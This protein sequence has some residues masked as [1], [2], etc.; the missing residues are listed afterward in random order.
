MAGLATEEFAQPG[1]DEDEGELLELLDALLPL[2]LCESVLVVVVG[3]VVGR[4]VHRGVRVGH[5]DDGG[6][7]A[8]KV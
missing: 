8:T 6:G 7:A 3:A 4:C 2:F 1:E 5:G